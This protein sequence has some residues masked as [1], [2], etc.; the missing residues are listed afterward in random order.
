MTP[1][2]PTP[3]DTSKTAP[4]HAV[5]TPPQLAETMVENARLRTIAITVMLEIAVLRERLPPAPGE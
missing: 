4:P 5:A 2:R 3:P 1:T